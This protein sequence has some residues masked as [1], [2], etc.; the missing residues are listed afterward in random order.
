MVFDNCSSCFYQ[1]D[2]TCNALLEYN[3]YIQYHHYVHV[4]ECDVFEC[5]MG[6]SPILTTEG[7]KLRPVYAVAREMEIRLKYR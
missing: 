6:Y 1:V 5:M 3:H 2:S 7:S 4:R